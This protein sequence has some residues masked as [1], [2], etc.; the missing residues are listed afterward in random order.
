MNSSYSFRSVVVGLLCLIIVLQILILS[1][2]KKQIVPNTGRA[3]LADLI[4][5][6]RDKGLEFRAVS[7]RPDGLWDQA[8]Y[9][10]TTEGTLADLTHW[11]VSPEALDKWKGTVVLMRAGPEGLSEGSIVFGEFCFFGDPDF[12]EKIRQTLRE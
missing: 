6:L 2:P 9:L 5:K 3:R 1:Q 11:P 8:V 7:Q 4:W 10:T 12:V